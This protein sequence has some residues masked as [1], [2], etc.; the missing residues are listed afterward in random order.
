[1]KEGL[2]VE[3]KCWRKGSR[4]WEKEVWKRGKVKGRKRGRFKMVGKRLKV[5]G[6]VRKGKG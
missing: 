4:W 2:S 6:R 1:M 5:K 3:G